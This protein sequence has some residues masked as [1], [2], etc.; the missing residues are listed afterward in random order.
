MTTGIDSEMLSGVKDMA[1]L[2]HSRLAVLAQG[3]LALATHG[4]CPE[5]VKT[6]ATNCT[7]DIFKSCNLRRLSQ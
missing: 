7:D 6:A 3:L 4:D 2:P 5:W 1:R